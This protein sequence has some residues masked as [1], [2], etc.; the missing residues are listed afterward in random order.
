MPEIWHLT[1]P[2]LLIASSVAYLF[3]EFDS[4]LQNFLIWKQL[5]QSN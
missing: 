5:Q 3:C 2:L 1:I 4:F